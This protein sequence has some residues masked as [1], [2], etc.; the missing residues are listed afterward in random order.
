MDKAPKAITASQ[1]A[2]IFI[3]TLLLSSNLPAAVIIDSIRADYQ[4]G[5]Y[6]K[7]NFDDTPYGPLPY[8]PDDIDLTTVTSLEWTFPTPTGGSVQVDMADFTNG[9]IGARIESTGEVS[10]TSF[11]LTF[12][13]GDLTSV[14]D[15]YLDI[16]NAGMALEFCPPPFGCTN[17]TS[18]AYWEAPSPAYTVASRAAPTSDV[19]EPRTLALLGLGLLALGATRTF[20]RDNNRRLFG[21]PAL[22]KI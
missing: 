9:Y 18:S 12:A 22:A 8:G 21:E 13:Q 10:I 5:A 17:G 2:V 1:T 6:F 7:L 20:S 16:T 11:F 19:P 3:S 4:T 15:Y 14:N